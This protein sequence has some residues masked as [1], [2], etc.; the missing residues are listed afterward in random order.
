MSS[1]PCESGAPV[2]GPACLT[3][4]ARGAWQCHWTEQPPESKCKFALC[5][6]AVG[7][8]YV[9]LLQMPRPKKPSGIILPR[10]PKGSRSYLACVDLVESL[11]NS[12][13]P[14]PGNSES[15]LSVILPSDLRSGLADCMSNPAAGLCCCGT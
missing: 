14:P 10:R 13:M 3:D 1:M 9:Q 12:K 5:K 15:E 4:V 6:L 2:L 11:T 7:L 8:V